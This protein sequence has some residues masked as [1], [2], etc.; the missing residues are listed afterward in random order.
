M[1]TMQ[2]GDGNNLDTTGSAGD[3]DGTGTI[4]WAAPNVVSA[5][6]LLG[7][8]SGAD[9]ADMPTAVAAGWYGVDNDFIEYN[10][11][12]TETSFNTAG[13][14]SAGD[15]ISISAGDYAVTLTDP[16]IDEDYWKLTGFTIRG[17]FTNS[18]TTGVKLERCWKK[19]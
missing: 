15:L 5:P 17:T 11:D 7:T 10:S 9:W 12:T 19:P 8:G 4:K 13:S 18:G 2:D 6:L 1:A 3:L 14:G 16:V